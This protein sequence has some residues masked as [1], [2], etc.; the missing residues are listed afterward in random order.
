MLLQQNHGFSRVRVHFSILLIFLIASAC[1]GGS[2]D[3]IAD[4]DRRSMLVR[5]NGAEATNLDPALAEDIHSFNILIDTYEGLVAE[6]ASGKIIPGVAR[7][8]Q[9]SDDGL[10]YTFSLRHD[11]RWSNGDRVFAGDFVRAFRHV[12]DSNTASFYASL[13]DT[14]VNF[15]DAI[16]G[17]K[18]SDSIGVQ[19]ISETMLRITLS[20]PTQHFLELLALPTAL[21]RHESGNHLVSNGPYQFD[22]EV[23]QRTRTFG[24]VPLCILKPS[25][26][27]Q[28]LTKWRNSICIGLARSMSHIIFPTK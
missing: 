10:V 22:K 24:T 16:A 25:D 5:G 28:L 15:R 7:S 4:T 6:D 27:F 3:G 11:A 9:V 12:A 2:D 13:F 23:N 14:I 20:A 21:P 1:G 18:P 17:D 8:W 26:T 19:A